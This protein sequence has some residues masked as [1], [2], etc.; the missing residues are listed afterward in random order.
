MAIVYSYPEG[1]PTLSDTLL[2][3]QFD[4]ESPAT[5][6]FSIADIVNLI[7][8]TTVSNSTAVALNQATLNTLYPNAMIGFKVQCV[9]LMSPKIYEKTALSVSG[10]FT[11]WVSYNI[12]LVA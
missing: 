11:T 6:S 4:Y 10:P 2:G 9:N 3:T 7:A 12:T 5:K 1:I 8:T